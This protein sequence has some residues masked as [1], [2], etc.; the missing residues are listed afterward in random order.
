MH[1]LRELY[2]SPQLFLPGPLGSAQSQLKPVSV[3]FFSLFFFFSFVL[4]FAPGLTFSPFRP[5]ASLLAGQ[6]ATHTHRERERES[7]GQTDSL[8]L[9][10]MEA[11]ST[12][13]ISTTTGQGSSIRACVSYWG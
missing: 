9:H 10:V 12:E 11:S 13:T 4:D 2:S 5:L 1:I 6:S 7:L 3:F 8:Y